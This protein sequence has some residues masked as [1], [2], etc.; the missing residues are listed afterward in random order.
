M[1]GAAGGSSGGIGA[2]A[3][4]LNPNLVDWA[5]QLTKGLTVPD[6]E[7]MAATRA[8]FKSYAAAQRKPFVME[9]DSLGTDHFWHGA[10]MTQWARDWVGLY[11]HGTGT[12]AVSDDE[13]QGILLAMTRLGSMGRVAINRLLILRTTSN[14]TLQPDGLTANQSLFDNLVGSS[15]YI[16]SLNVDYQVGKVVVNALLG[17]WA[18][19]ETHTP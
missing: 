6:T 19:Y 3:W 10:I 8:K 18:R 2:M 5:F 7:G 1:A 13:D 14:F 17:N 16:P 12:F 11:T 4:K 9:G 15:G